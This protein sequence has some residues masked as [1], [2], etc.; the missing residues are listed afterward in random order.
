MGYP[1]TSVMD[2]PIG[3]TVQRVSDEYIGAVSITPSDTA[4]LTPEYVRALVVSAPGNVKVTM[5]DGSVVTLP[6]LIAGV[7]WKVIVSRVWLNGTSA[8]GIVGLY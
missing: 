3:G 5:L 4:P 7:V 1:P 2:S 8:I 6:M